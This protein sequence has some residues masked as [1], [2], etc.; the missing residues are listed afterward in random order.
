[1]IGKLTGRLDY[2]AADHILL[3]VQ[4][5]GY[6]VY[7]SE[8]TLAVM[9]APGGIVALYTELLVR[10]DNLQLFGFLTLAE[11][12]WHR[13]LTSV[14]GVGAR[15]ALAVAGT[16][17]TE[18]VSRAIALGDV[19]A[20]K[21][22]PGVGPKLAQRVIVELKDKAPKVMAMGAKGAAPVQADAS[23]VIEPV[24]GRPETHP[25]PPGQAAPAAAQSDAL[26]ALL[27]LGYAQGEAAGAVAQASGDGP[28][29]DSGA[30]IKAALKLLAPKG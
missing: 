12:E 24:I 4:G 3:D 28:Q 14:Q 21:S 11:K 29:A 2:R 17:G 8:R 13:L 10:E 18:G 20:I 19:A 23:V 26:S 1:M 15:V 27:N 16:L 5:V 30:L 25:A 9:P 6:L 22:A 7:C